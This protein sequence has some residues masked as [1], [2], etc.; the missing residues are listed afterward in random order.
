MITGCGGSPA[1]GIIT[2]DTQISGDQ[3]TDGKTSI[4]DAGED[5]FAESDMSAEDVLGGEDMP[6]K[7]TYR[8]D[9]HKPADTGIDTGEDVEEDTA[10]PECGALGQSCCPG[11]LCDGA[12]DCVNGK[13]EESA[14]GCPNTP[15]C[16]VPSPGEPD[17][18]ITLASGAP[19]N[20]TGG[21]VS[22]GTFELSSIQVYADSTFSTM[23]Q[24][25]DIHSNGNTYGSLEIS[26]ADWGLSANLDMYVGLNILLIG[27]IVQ[28]TV[29][30]LYAGGC[31][32]ISGNELQSDITECTAGWPE[33]VPPPDS[34][35]FQVDAN[36]ISLLIVLTQ[37][38][39]ISMVPPE[40]QQYASLAIVGDLP[41]LMNF[42]SNP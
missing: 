23:V 2:D 37:E 31:F 11:Q 1:D 28:S 3:S 12:L 39:L 10:E 42:E 9:T 7:D 40:Y 33:G 20:L 6:Q 26:G 18:P 17:V 30:S 36:G 19:P 13:C 35:E 8:V 24:S 5:S 25:V 22:S 41:I 29:Q 21:T 16:I 27:P 38:Y 4:K 34:F 32:T 15:S 14:S